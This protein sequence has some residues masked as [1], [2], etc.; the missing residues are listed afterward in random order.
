M[1]VKKNSANDL[2]M[3]RVLHDWRDRDEDGT[4]HNVALKLSC[5]AMNSRPIQ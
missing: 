4:L 5:K 1:H 2:I 3:C